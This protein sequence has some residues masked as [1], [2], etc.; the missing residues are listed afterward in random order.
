MSKSARSSS[1]RAA[2]RGAGDRVGADAADGGGS[3]VVGVVGPAVG[4]GA[5]G[6]AVD[7]QDEG[8]GRPKWSAS[9]ASTSPRTSSHR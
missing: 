6:V 9:A 8:D 5:S 2:G 4:V 1:V 3:R 7:H